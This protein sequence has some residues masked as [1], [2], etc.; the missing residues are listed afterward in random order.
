[1]R[2]SFEFVEFV[3]FGNIQHAC[4]LK[5][6]R[7]VHVDY[8]TTFIHRKHLK[9]L[10]WSISIMIGILILRKHFSK[11]ALPVHEFCGSCRAGK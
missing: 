10:A 9:T 5:G 8:C 11:R 6:A 3:E 2:R 7:G 1:M 4:G